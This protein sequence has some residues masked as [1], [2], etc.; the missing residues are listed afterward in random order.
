MQDTELPKDFAEKRADKSH[1]KL[2]QHTRLPG[3]VP[4]SSWEVT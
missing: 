1:Q 4:L 3:T 2:W